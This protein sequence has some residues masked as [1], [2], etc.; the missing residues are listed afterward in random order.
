MRTVKLVGFVLVLSLAGGVSAYG[1]IGDDVRAVT[2]EILNDPDPADWLMWRRTYNGWGYSPLDQ[3]N[4][5]N[6]D[7]MQLVWSYALDPYQRGVQAEPIVYGGVIYLRHPSELVSAH[8]AAT[9]DLIWSYRRELP[10]DIVRVPGITVHRGRGMSLYGNKLINFSTDGF[11]YALDAGTGELIWEARMVDY[12]ETR[13]QAS[14]APIVYN[15]V[16]VVPFNCTHHSSMRTCHLSAYDAE[17]GKMLWRWF[18]SPGPDDPLHDT[19]GEDPQRY[20]LESRLNTSAWMT[21][22]VDTERG[23]F[24][25]GVGS[26]APMQPEVVGT[27]GKW[28]D[29]LY[30]GSTVALDHRTSKVVWW[31]QHQS[32]MHNNDSVFDRILVD[33]RVNPHDTEAP[34]LGR[35]PDIRPGQTRQLVVGSFS[36]DGIFYVYDRTNGE[37]LYA[38]ETAPQNVIASYDGE[39][40]AYTM[41]PETVMM[42]DTD[43]VVT[44]CKENRMIPQGAYSPLTNAYYVPVWA[45]CAEFRTGSLTPKRNEGYNLSTLRSFINPKSP[46][47]GRPEAIDVSTG[48]TLWRLDREVPFYGMLTTGGGLLFAADTNRRF[49]AL[50]QWTGEVLWQTILSGLSDMAPITYSVSGRQY[51]AVIS[52]GGTGV[53]LSHL[54]R[55]NIRVPAVGHT[56]F[57]FALPEDR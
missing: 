5:D 39:T 47:F 9:G 31:A 57:V 51:L 19:W 29:R 2:Q 26:S 21:P 54:L 46:T 53:A 56:L 48:K 44:A 30:H 35:N 43:R 20:P 41:N 1:Q 17:T 37:F 16:V 32:D 28:P 45:G 52:P 36:K 4:R 18:T 22:A 42:A 11:L 14:G 50:D 10:E 27:D 7:K 55:L 6:V 33:A 13:Q 24:I 3:I 40:G 8:D 12:R 38:R 49:Y 25:F 23:L 34:W 15:G